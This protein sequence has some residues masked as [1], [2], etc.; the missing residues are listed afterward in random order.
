[1]DRLRERTRNRQDTWK[2]L[3]T[4]TV[5]IGTKFHIATSS[6][7]SLGRGESRGRVA[8]P[9]LGHDYKVTPYVSHLKIEVYDSSLE[10]I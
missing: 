9:I 10:Y 3:R 1:M 6:L 2:I 4:E 8:H 7:Y 5:V